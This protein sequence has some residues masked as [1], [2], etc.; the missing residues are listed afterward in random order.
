MSTQVSGRVRGALAGGLIA[1]CAL[2]PAADAADADA[3]AADKVGSQLLPLLES[4]V[5]GADQAG[6]AGAT[7][8]RGRALVDVYVRGGLDRAVDRLEAAGMTV[9]ATATEP[10]PV[11]EGWIPVDQV[12]AGARLTSTRAVLPVIGGN[13]DVGAVTSEGVGAHNLPAA[14]TS[15]GANG[16]GVDVG[17]ISDSIDQVGGGVDDS[18][19][20]GDLPPDP[21]VVVLNDDTTGGTADEGRAMAEIIYD[22][23]PGLNRILFSTGTETGPVGKAASINAL[24]ANG[25]D[26][27][28]DDI[29]YLEEPFFQD[30]AVAQAV[31]A[32]RAAGVA[33]F[34][35]AGNRARQSY[36]SSYRDAAGLHDFD[37]GGGTDT[38]SCF[39]SPVPNGDFI[40]VA[41]QWA[42]PLDN[43]TTNLDLRITTSGGTTLGS[44]T[45]NNIVTGIPREIA[46][47][48]NT[49]AAVQP[50][51]EI[52][53]V[54]GTGTPLMKWI[55]FDNYGPTPVPEFDTASNTINPDAASAGGSLSVAAVNVND[56]GHDT[57]ETFSS[58]GPNTRFFNAAGVPF[59][60]PQVRNNPDLAAADGVNTTVPGF[61]PFFGTSAATPSAAGIA[62]VLRSAG[63]STDQIYSR[64]TNTANA[65]DCSLTAGQPDTDC[66]AG[67]V[68]ANFASAGLD[69]TPP[70][71]STAVNPSVPTGNNG[72][73][74]GDVTVSLSAADAQSTVQSANGCGNFPVTTD[75][76]K[77]FAC[78]AVSS[79]GTGT[80]S[81]SVKRDSQPP[82]KPKIKGIRKH[83]KPPPKRKLKCKSSD[84]TSGIASCTLE[85]YSRKP[86]KHKVRA[87][88]TDNAGLTSKSKLKYKVR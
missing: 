25:A 65:I 87:I 58:R 9:Q 59:G 12:A 70:V 69:G 34:A 67:F 80:G 44:S 73:Y 53:R 45:T 18:Q 72:W 74:T 64:M 26:V 43:V 49:G 66:G 16:N 48:S 81:V 35:S 10:L 23:A 39:N 1:A 15:T 7:I 50:C 30:G 37:P 31:D 56:S 68:L 62:A 41:L 20:T 75:G 36:E 85:G 27:I 24:V 11:A 3:S 82:S 17:V 54:A 76:V 51:V 32:A 6:D 13:T 14:I 8:E 55:E 33:Y 78:T 47:F 77:T 38:R 29:F 4:G 71:V 46:F 21:R 61:D 42:E 22:E 79:G 2:A 60:S 84:E 86:G 5:D 19:T 88:A 83:R 52:S 57:P 40:L 63:A 28:A